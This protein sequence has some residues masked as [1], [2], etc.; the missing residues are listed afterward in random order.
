[1]FYCY[2]D[3]ADEEEEEEEPKAHGLA[4]AR[5]SN[6]LVLFEERCVGSEAS[7]PPQHNS[8]APTLVPSPRAPKPKKAKTGAGSTQE[9][10]T[11]TTSGPLLEDVSFLSLLVA[12]FV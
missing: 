9:L 10:A 5:T 3:S 4:A 11:G 8:E 1:L 2:I 12:N 7:S 6:T